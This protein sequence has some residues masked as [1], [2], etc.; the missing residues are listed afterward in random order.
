M[1]SKIL[2]LSI[3]AIIISFFGGFYLA[4]S[5]NGSELVKLRAENEQLKKNPIGTSQ[6]NND[7]DGLSDVEIRQKI[8]EADKSP[9][10]IRYQRDLGMALLSYGVMKQ[11]IELIS[12]STRLLQRAY[13]SNPKDFDVLVALGNA[14]Y[15]IASLKNDTESFKKSREFYSKALEQ[16]PDNASVRADYGSTFVF[17]NP[18]DFERGS[19]ELQKALQIDPKNERALLLMTQM[20]VKQNK[21][22]D[23]EKYL[24]KLRE[25]NPKAPSLEELNAQMAQDN[26]P[27]QKQ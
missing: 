27:I 1:N 25:I 14:Y 10:N 12:E 2:W 3:L 20:L 16:K 13:D 19:A 8:D 22:A 6:N 7:D 15:D 23:A 11:N 18:P 21:P 24:A 9:G 17:V 5:L 26:N 4:N